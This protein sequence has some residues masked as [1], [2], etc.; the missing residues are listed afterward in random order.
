MANSWL[1]GDSS[2][3]PGGD[4]AARDVPAPAAA[5]RNAGPAA[6]KTPPSAARVTL[7]DR[8]EADAA[9]ACDAAHERESQSERSHAIRRAADDISPSDEELVSAVLGG[10]VEAF[11]PLV[12]RYQHEYV[13]F[14][15]R[16][17]GSRDDADEAL[18]AA[19]LRAYRAL[20]QCRD[21]RRFGAWLYHIVANEC[22]T[23][24]TRTGRRERRFVRDEA[25]LERALTEHPADDDALRDEIQHALDQLPDDQRE[26]FVLKHVEELSYDEMAEVTGAGTSALKMRVKRACERLRE[27]LESVHHD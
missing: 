3:D 18:Q 1:A 2:S 13:R 9:P 7:A 19:F 15:R 27:L 6:R 10:D 12:D 25:A 5:A 4:G 21:P 22:R 24:A 20:E 14:A 16:M 11:G 8:A 17:L 23:R 26:A